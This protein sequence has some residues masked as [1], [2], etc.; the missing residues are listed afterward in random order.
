MKKIGVVIAIYNTDK[1]LSECIESVIKQTYKNIEIALVN[2]GSDDDSG[3]ICD[4]YAARNKRIKVIHQKNQGKLIARYNGAKILDCD[5]LTFVDSD[6]WIDL[7]TYETFTEQMEEDIDII[8]WQIIRYLDRNHQK[9][10]THNF[11]L[12]FYDHEK[13]INEFYPNMIWNFEKNSFGI[14][15]SICN[16]LFKKKLVLEALKKA[17]RLINVS[18]GDDMAAV[19]PAMKEAHNLYLS[20]KFFYYHRKRLNNEIP[21]YLK[22]KNFFNKLCILYDYLVNIFNEKDIFVKQLDAFFE[23]SV[24]IRNSYF[25]KQTLKINTFLFPFKDIPSHSDIVIYGAGNV[26]KEYY[27]QLVLLDYANSILWVDKNYKNIKDYNIKNPAIL[28][29]YNDYDYIVIAVE[30]KEI[31]EQIQKYLLNINAPKDKIIW[32]INK[33]NIER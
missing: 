11:P 20:D 29:D 9:K 6:D 21:P 33:Y 13:Y 2:D 28:R 14:N 24:K 32:N 27:N 17:S 16:K 18:Y 7:K 10:A 22:D 1:Y 26:G 5:Y 30:K 15:P 3:K 25:I 4:E 23:S 12:G 8:S 31:A 19:Y